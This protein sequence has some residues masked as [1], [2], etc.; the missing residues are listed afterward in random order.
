MLFNAACVRGELFVHPDVKCKHQAHP[1]LINKVRRL[2]HSIDATQRQALTDL[3]EMLHTDY[4]NHII[5]QGLFN[6]CMQQIDAF[7]DEV[8]RSTGL[9]TAELSADL[10]VDLGK[11]MEPARYNLIQSALM[12][13][14]LDSQATAQHPADAVL[15][16]RSLDFVSRTSH[17]TPSTGYVLAERTARSLALLQ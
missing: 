3:V 6:Q 10:A 12:G 16:K 9:E 7:L 5:N 8:Q 11:L 2:P 14:V 1:P 13:V 4:K 15:S 17:P